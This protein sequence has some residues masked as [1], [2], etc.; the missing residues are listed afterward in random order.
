VNQ[1]PDQRKDDQLPQEI[2]FWRAV[3][4]VLQ[5]SFGVQSAENRKRD[6]QSR[7]IMPYVVAAL[8]FTAAFILVL[9]GVVALVLPD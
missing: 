5:A 2:S 1:A 3:V 4:S 8:L 9:A 7:S 6:F